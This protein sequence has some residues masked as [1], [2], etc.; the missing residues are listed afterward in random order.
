MAGTAGV[1]GSA[2]G[3]G[4]AA[5]F[6]SPKAIAV[7]GGIIYVADSGNS[8]I[9]RIAAD[10]TVTT[11]AGA[12]G[13]IGT[14]NGTGGAARFSAPSG[15]AVSSSGEVFVADTDNHAIRK[16]TTAGVVS[17]FAG[18]AGSFGATNDTGAAARFKSPAG[19]AFDASGNLYVSDRDNFRIRKITPSAV[20]TTLA[21]GNFSGNIDGTGTAARFTRPVGIAMEPSGNLVVTDEHA[22]LIRRVTTTGAVTTPAGTASALGFQDGVGSAARFRYPTGV[23][24]DAAGTAFVVDT[25]NQAIRAV[26]ATAVVTTY[27]GRF[28]YGNADGNAADARFWEPNG[29]A[30]DAA[31]NIY[32]ADSTN[33]T[34]RKI[35]P[36]GVVSTLAGLA[37]SSGYVDATGSA[38]RFFDPRGIALDGNGN[39]FVA[40][41]NK[42]RKITPAGEVTTFGGVLSGVY[43]PVGLAFDSAGNLFA[44]DVGQGGPNIFKFTPDGQRTT[45]L[46]G[47]ALV[48]PSAFTPSGLAIDA[49]DNLY[50][51]ETANHVI[52]KISPTGTVT[53]FAGTAGVF[54]STDGFGAA[55][56][57]K[58]YHG[59]GGTIFTGIAVD[60]TGNVFV[61]DSQNQT[62]R[63]ISLVGQVTTVGGTAGQ[64]GIIDGIGP[65]AR[66]H[67][68]SGLAVDS[69]GNLIVA[70][71]GSHTIRRGG[72]ILEVP[73]ITSDNSASGQVGVPF[74]YQVIAS[75]AP[76]AYS[77][78]GLPSGLV[79]NV[80]TGFIAGTPLVSGTFG[81][82]LSAHNSAGI[83]TSEMQLI[84]APVAINYTV[85][86]VIGTN[87]ARS[88]GGEL[89]QTITHGAAAIAPSIL[90]NSGW[91]FTDWDMAF[92][93]VTTDLEIIATYVAA[94][95]HTVTFSLG[96]NGYGTR[97]GGGELVQ[98]VVQAGSAMPPTVAV[99]FGQRFIGWDQPLSNITGN[100]LITAVY[101]AYAVWTVTFDLGT[102]G[103]HVGGGALVQVIEEPY[104][105]V[106]PI[107]TVETNWVFVGWDLPFNAIS[108]NL[109]VTAIYAPASNVVTFDPNTKGSRTGGGALSQNVAYL[110]A[111]EAP[112]IT[113]S[114]GW[115]FVGWDLPF[116]SVIG[117]LQ[118]RAV[119]EAIAYTD[120][121]DPAP[122]TLLW[123]LFEGEVA[124]NTHG[125]AA[126]AGSSGNSLWF[127]G[128]GTRAA[129]TVP[130]DTLWSKII[131]FKIALGNGTTP[132]E[133]VN[134][135][136][137]EGIVLEYSV[138]GGTFSTLAG[139]LVN[140]DW[141]EFSITLPQAAKS[142][143]TR[144]R[145]R[146]LSHSGSSYD[147]WA[148]EDL[149][150]DHSQPTA[151]NSAPTA[152]AKAIVINASTGAV[153]LSGSLSTDSDGTI[154]SYTWTWSGGSTTGVSPSVTLSSGTTIL[155]LIVTDNQG[156]TGTTTVTVHVNDL[157]RIL[158]QAGLSGP[159]SLPS[160]TPFNDGVSNLLKYAFNM[161]A[162][163]PDVSVITPSG[164]SGLP[165]IAV[166][167]S[168]AEPVLRVAFLRR[169]GSGLIYTPQ[170]STTLCDFVAMTGTQTVT[171]ID[172][173]WERVT[174]QEPAPPATAPSAFARVQVSL[175]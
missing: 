138:G 68:P 35:S 48:L 64:A 37:G 61:S 143:H 25:R 153:D 66:F 18:T 57:F 77:A 172:S 117:N 123:A 28:D 60:V 26:S 97:T 44:T 146:Q 80:S 4:T 148:I 36:A 47:S 120:V 88:G 164:S 6:L 87:G 145:F 119:Y 92:Q 40:D 169:K 84:I 22:Y 67:N 8:T 111:A 129:T 139:P 118:I 166:D 128:D 38:A 127:N 104:G 95:I 21:G 10:G 140:K 156:A 155:T 154:S 70:T 30:V 115:T 160:A 93:N 14:T 52:L 13:G 132:W 49:S 54:G 151:V 51:V 107:V 174:V 94:P 144:F 72:P 152:L 50:V 99:A 62:I 150:M 170:R 42:I 41:S 43:N 46:N 65:A 55:A 33:R 90:A 2:D 45:F 27:A 56:R 83:G 78:T 11:L 157:G 5:R 158:L 76:T 131:R 29:T 7:A 175:P 96:P 173:Q 161:N 130:L 167:S 136:E 34:I 39:V 24:V 53:T 19:L 106:E 168:G 59:S 1:S 125:Q 137:G 162:A 82:V 3:L 32:V 85:T 89:V 171:S 23:I 69:L 102:R 116:D 12:P 141:R 142:I 110:A 113:P 75:E 114:L 112:L 100:I 121:F 149:F 122:N 17:T 58:F 81:V 91:I 135:G 165:Q 159:D 74:S 105:A 163:G 124:A 126:G 98:S 71:G 20:V 101:E 73:V 103:S 16:V 79:C 15:L 86:F 63:Q 9:R 134:T 109:T 31:G 133:D 147:H 108:S